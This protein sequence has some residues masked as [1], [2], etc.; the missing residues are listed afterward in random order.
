MAYEEDYFQC[1]EGISG[2]MILKALVNARKMEL[3]VF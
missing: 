3:S 1:T 2:N